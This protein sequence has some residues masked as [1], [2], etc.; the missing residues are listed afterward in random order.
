MTGVSNCFKN[1]R[2]TGRVPRLAHYAL[3]EIPGKGYVTD[4]GFCG[5]FCWLWHNIRFPIQSLHSK[6][7]NGPT[8]LQVSDDAGNRLSPTLGRERQ[9]WLRPQTSTWE[10]SSCQ[11]DLSCRSRQGCWHSRP[12]SPQRWRRRT[13]TADADA[14]APRVPEQLHALRPARAPPSHAPMSSSPRWLRTPH[15]PP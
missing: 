14:A 8:G 5:G 13:T 10:G 4:E 15:G 3:T 7:W 9:F 6:F 2:Y 12:R 1:H 11:A